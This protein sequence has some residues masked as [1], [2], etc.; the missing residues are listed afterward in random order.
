M[1]FSMP[2]ALRRHKKITLLAAILAK[3]LHASV[4]ML[5]GSRLYQVACFICSGRFAHTVATHCGNKAT[6][7]RAAGRSF[8]LGSAGNFV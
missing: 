3:V 7:C 4:H 6:P 1:V 5:T 8:A 2:S